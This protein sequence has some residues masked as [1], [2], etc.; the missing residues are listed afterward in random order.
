MSE[1]KRRTRPDRIPWLLIL[2]ATLVLGTV[3]PAHAADADHGAK[4][5]RTQCAECHSTQESKNR[6]GP[7]LFGVVGRHAGT[8]PEYR[9]S[10]AM[11]H[12]K[13]IWTD[14]ELDA[15]IT[16]PRKVVPGCKMKYRGLADS[17]KRADVIAYLNTAR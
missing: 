16:A 4:V 2:A 1:R 6:T 13:L 10:D 15:Y 12:S 5:F 11:K 17:A 3:R 9:Y 14:A 7:S 8:V